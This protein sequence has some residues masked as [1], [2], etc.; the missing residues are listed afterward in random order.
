LVNEVF[1]NHDALIAGVLAV[2]K[3]IAARSP[4]AV[5]GSKEM[6]NYA[7]DHSVEDSLRYMAAWQSGMFHPADMF[8]SFVAKSEKREPAFED[9]APIRRFTE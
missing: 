8:E 5:H 1:P 6:L 7:R 2:A 3:E 4:L 9:L